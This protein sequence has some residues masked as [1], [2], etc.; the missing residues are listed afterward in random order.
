VQQIIGDYFQVRRDTYVVRKE[1][2]VKEL[3]KEVVVL[4]NKARYIG[5]VLEGSV[6]LRNMKRDAIDIMLEEKR[7]DRS[8]TDKD[9]RYL[10]KMTMDSVCQENVERLLQEKGKKE[11]E[12]EVL[13]NT[14]I[15]A[16]WNNEL[17]ELE[18]VYMRYR[19]ERATIMKNVQPETETGK[20]VKV[21]KKVM[22]SRNK[23]TK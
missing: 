9:F 8:E 3:T 17:E 16:M 14:C 12:L 6:D 13:S 23:S 21:K 22:V 7:Y 4:S 15:E 20:K 10:I 2:M 19:E 5:E 1:H 11:T 18:E